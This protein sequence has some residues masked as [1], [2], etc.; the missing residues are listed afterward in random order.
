MLSS[1][2]IF[3][4]I[5]DPDDTTLVQISPGMKGL[6]KLTAN[7]YGYNY[8]LSQQDWKR[9]SFLWVLKNCDSLKSVCLGAGSPEGRGG[10]MN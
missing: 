3:K 2:V 9:F 5:K 8:N 10:G 1:K 4:S 6:I 7:A